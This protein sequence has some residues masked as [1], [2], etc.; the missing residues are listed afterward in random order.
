MKKVGIQSVYS[1]IHDGFESVFRILI[2]SLDGTLEARN[3]YFTM[4]RVCETKKD[5]FD[6]LGGDLIT[7]THA[8]R[9]I[10]QKQ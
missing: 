9:A 1:E 3:V 10:R 5:D 8:R 4:S 7:E 6:P 2:A